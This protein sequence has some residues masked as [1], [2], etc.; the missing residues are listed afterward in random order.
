MSDPV[1]FALIGCGPMGAATARELVLS[2]PR[3]AAPLQ[4]TLVDRDAR[5]LHALAAGLPASADVA[6]EA[7]HGDAAHHRT[8][9]LLAEQTVLATA[10]S[11]VD[12][13]PALD[14]TLEHGLRLVG[15]GRP[16]ADPRTELDGR[17]SA[18]GASIVVGAGLEPGLTEILARRLAQDLDVGGTVH[19][20][21]GGVPR[22][23]RPPMHHVSW[24]GT[25]MTID[26]RP[27]YQFRGGVLRQV[28]RFSGVEL[29]DV[30]GLGSLEAFHDGLS[31]YVGADAVLGSLADY[32]AKTL[33]WRG[34]ADRVRLLAEIGLLGGR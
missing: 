19:S 11:W 25:R 1:R 29:V 34:Y 14:L 20:Y 33:R 4:L 15:I 12:A 22:S 30:P 32:T 28:E 21:C 17:A 31:P 18:S 5:R 16:P 24:Y 2:W 9:Q 13:A 10:L 3:H 6:V 7:H 23:P 8:R 27:T 26:A